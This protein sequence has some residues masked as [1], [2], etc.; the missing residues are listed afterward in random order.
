VWG[1]GYATEGS[2]AL[3]D[4]AFTDLPVRRIVAETAGF[5]V[6]SRRV[7][8]KSGLRLVREYASRYPPLGPDDVLGDVEYAITR[9]E[10]EQQRRSR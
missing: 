4:T 7:L 5:H 6:A 9:E 8:E 2:R 1:R 10:W 3:I